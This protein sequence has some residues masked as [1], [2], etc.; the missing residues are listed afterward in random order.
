MTEDDLNKIL[1]RPGY[2]ISE[3][4]IK[5]CIGPSTIESQIKRER[6]IDNL[7]SASSDESLHAKKL[8]VNYSGK[9]RVCF[10]FYRRRLADYSRAISEKALVDCLQYAGL[11]EGDSEKEIWLQDGGQKKVETDEEERTEI[12]IFYESVDLD[13]LWIPAKQNKAR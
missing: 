7:E 12:E 13:N 8:Q 10:T 2:S 5:S 1:S 9:V 11:I 6:E 4:R 3:S